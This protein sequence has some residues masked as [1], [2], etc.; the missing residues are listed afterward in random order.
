MEPPKKS[1]VKLIG[2]RFPVAN[3]FFFWIRKK[4][5]GIELQHY[6]RGISQVKEISLTNI[7]FLSGCWFLSVP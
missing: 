5:W 4:G 2:S 3:V 1:I 6:S 7:F